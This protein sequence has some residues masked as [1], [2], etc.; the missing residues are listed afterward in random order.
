[1][2]AGGLGFGL[3]LG[4]GGGGGAGTFGPTGG[5]G[6][7]PKLPL[8]VTVSAGSPHAVATGLFIASPA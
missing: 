1:M 2:K 5:S 8:T 4:F 3:G 7:G 6:L